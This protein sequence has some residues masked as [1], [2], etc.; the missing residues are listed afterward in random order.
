MKILILDDDTDRAMSW[1]EA[2]QQYDLL[3]IDVPNKKSTSEPN[4]VI[5]KKGVADIIADLHDVRLSSRGETSPYQSSDVFTGYD[6]VIIDYDLLGL[7]SSNGSAWSTGAEVAYAAR[8]MSDTGPIIVVNQYG[9]NPFDLT[10]KRAISSYAD[11]D[12]GNEQITDSGLWESSQFEKFRPWHW[13]DLSKETA[14]FNKMKDFIL[15]NLDHPIMDVLGFDLVDVCSPSFIGR[16]IAGHLGVDGSK[17]I[18]F[19]ELITERRDIRVFNIL[20]K[21]LPIIRKMPAEQQARLASVIVWHWLEKVVLP[22]QEVLSDLPHLISKFP[23]LAKEYSDVDVW[24]ALCDLSKP[25]NII[26][27]LAA[28][29]FEPFFM[30]SRPVYW[31]EHVKNNL[32]VPNDFEIQKLPDLVFCEDASSFNL[33]TNSKNY[34]SDLFSFDKERWV[35]GDLKCGA[36]PVNYEP[37]SYLLM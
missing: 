34:P 5:V 32:G 6:L 22:N 29:R 3:E 7:E 25:A 23:W 8:L 26:D 19:R 12:L 36:T 10:M 35:K 27:E 15:V 33:R 17:K 14:R 30:F 13:P 16:D 37:Q 1:K 4:G 9:T 28:H 20:E 24:A 21:D 18:T 2:I 31:A 11:F